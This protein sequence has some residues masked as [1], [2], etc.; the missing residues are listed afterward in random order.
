MTPSGC[1]AYCTRSGV[2]RL[3]YKAHI[4]RPRR[5]GQRRTIG[6]ATPQDEVFTDYVPVFM[7]K[8][9]PKR[10]SGCVQT[11]TIALRLP[12]VSGCVVNPLVSPALRRSVVS[13][14]GSSPFW[15]SAASLSSSF[16]FWRSAVSPLSG[17]P[18][19][20]SVVSLLVSPSGGFPFR[21]STVS[22]VV[23]FLDPVHDSPRWSFHG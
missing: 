9:I 16:P 15:H 6:C 18:F 23:S 8:E 17:F 10:S 21:R 4:S 14:S 12:P 13:F 20:R 22:P 11:S 5:A 2:E 3:Y 19:W 7:R 1:Q